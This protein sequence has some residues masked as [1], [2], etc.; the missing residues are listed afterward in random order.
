MLL[1]LS[2]KT[3]PDVTFAVS[4]VARF[5]HA[6]K[7]SHAAAVK[8]ILRYLSRTINQGLIITKSDQLLLAVYPDTDFAGLFNQDPSSSTSSAKSTTGYLIKLAGCP[9]L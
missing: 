8:K 6:P 3:R 4:Q 9:L 7:A 2:G 5:T 1:Y